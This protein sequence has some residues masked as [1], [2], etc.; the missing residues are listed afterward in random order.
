MAGLDSDSGSLAPEPILSHSAIPP[1]QYRE[2]D[3]NWNGGNQEILQRVVKNERVQPHG[4]GHSRQRE[5]LR[6]ET[7]QS[8][9]GSYW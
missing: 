3:A 2:R 9:W 1:P 7:T 8:I 6:H 4:E 5:Q